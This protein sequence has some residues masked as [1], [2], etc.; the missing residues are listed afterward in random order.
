MTT[1]QLVL[2]NEARC[3][4]LSQYGRNESGRSAP[5]RTF[6]SRSLSSAPEPSPACLLLR[7]HLVLLDKVSVAK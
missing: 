7:V 2:F 4:E 1:A 5:K 3:R 6:A